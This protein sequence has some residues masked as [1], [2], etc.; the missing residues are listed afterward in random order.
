MNAHNPLDGAPSHRDASDISY[1]EYHD[2]EQ[3]AMRGNSS[4]GEVF[5]AEDID[6]TNPSDDT[7]RN[8]PVE[9]GISM[10]DHGPD[11][12]DTTDETMSIFDEDF[13]SLIIYIQDALVRPSLSPTLMENF[14][15]ALVSL[16]TIRQIASRF[17]VPYSPELASQ[18]ASSS[19]YHTQSPPLGSAAIRQN[20]RARIR[21]EVISVI[22][23]HY[24][25]YSPML[26]YPPLPIRYNNPY[27]DLIG[28]RSLDDGT[29]GAYAKR[30]SHD[31]A[32]RMIFT[33]WRH[34]GLYFRRGH[35]HITTADRNLVEVRQARLLA[36]LQTQEMDEEIAYRVVQGPKMWGT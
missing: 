30:D 20:E 19:V 32:Y 3:H 31:S 9:G 4:Y 14:S 28:I 2:A 16:R 35:M 18:H 21:R 8:G 23:S 24:I 34:N 1:N 33:D 26:A 22:R 12:T 10:P 7:T 25:I 13:E 36:G 15:N 29:I 11:D 17:R 5:N 27:D 6:F